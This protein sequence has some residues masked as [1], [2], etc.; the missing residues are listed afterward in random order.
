MTMALSKYYFFGMTFLV[1][2]LL[3]A[4]GG[5]SD[6]NRDGFHLGTNSASYLFYLGSLNAVDSDNPASPIVVEP[7]EDIINGSIE[8]VV[9]ADYDPLTKTSGNEQSYALIYAKSDGR[10]YKV[11]AL[12]E[13]SL[14]PE[15]LSSESNANQM[16]TPLSKQAVI[17]DYNNP[18][19][20]QYLYSLPGV[21]AV[22]GTSDDLL[23]MVRL[24]MSANDAPIEAKK[25]L[26]PLIDLNNGGISGWLV[27]DAGALKT[28][29]ANFRNC[30]ATIANVATDAIFWLDSRRHESLLL[31]IDQ[32]FFIYNIPTQ[33]LSLPR[34]TRSS[35]TQ[36]V[37]LAVADGSMVYLADEDTLYQF[38]AD[39]SDDAVVLWVDPVG[40]GNLKVTTNKV[41]YKSGD[42]L[43]A[44]DKTG[45]AAITLVSGS[46]NLF[47]STSGDLVYYSYALLLYQPLSGA[48]LDSTL[49]QHFNKAG[50]VTAG[51]DILFERGNAQWVFQVVGPRPI[52]I[53]G[54]S[55]LM[56]V[57]T[58][59]MV[60]ASGGSSGSGHSL[61]GATL[62]SFN[63]STG[64]AGPILGRLPD[65]NEITYL[66]C[67]QGGEAMLCHTSHH[68]R[69]ATES[70]V[71]VFEGDVYF[72]NKAEAG[73]LLRITNTPEKPE[74][75][76]Y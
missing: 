74:S 32:Q 51:G 40:V 44:V 38:P 49:V 15:Q 16:C 48:S 2:L 46:D 20:S 35:S 53:G 69:L 76:L 21:D 9:T 67:K 4:C 45:G 28:C 33:T 31:E 37:G 10:L 61:P 73:S 68:I 54:E 13:R 39:G 70:V 27:N 23:R 17:S 55:D 65:D 72:V 43:K 12:K 75:A 42:S 52:W 24:G 22:C 50:I 5:S 63:T 56:N 18:G 30:G 1:T 36:A 66:F 8:T 34:F 25:A 26:R 64:Q 14:I 3:A 59:T 19:N 57:D 71:T 60:L 6:G 7:G 58:T 11:N 41:I 29:D 47:Y 62:Q